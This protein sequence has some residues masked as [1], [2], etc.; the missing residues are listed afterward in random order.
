MLG[1][2]V[3]TMSSQVSTSLRCSADP[4]F[5][6]SCRL[7]T[8]VWPFQTVTLETGGWLALTATPRDRAAWRRL[9]TRATS[10]TDT[11]LSSWKK[12]NFCYV[13][14]LV[15]CYLL[16]SVTLEASRKPSVSTSFQWSSH[17]SVDRSRRDRH[18]Q[19]V[20]CSM[21]RY[22]TIWNRPN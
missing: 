16:V 9:E 20:V 3:R 10:M 1:P 4:H 5:S 2:Q 12:K 14:V 19:F 13:P 11:I 21:C 8:K 22:Q 7:E 17:S 6:R 15:T 18:W